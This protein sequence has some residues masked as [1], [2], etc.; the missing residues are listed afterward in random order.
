MSSIGYVLYRLINFYELII[1]AQCILSWFAMT[2]NSV[3]YDVYQALS[4]ITEP[5]IG[6]FRRLLSSVGVGGMQIDFSPMVA[7]IV[8]D[9]IKR[10][11][12]RF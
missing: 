7:I 5:F 9:L 12:I 1:L 6:I 4:K 8:L 2:G 10:V 11:V 3:I